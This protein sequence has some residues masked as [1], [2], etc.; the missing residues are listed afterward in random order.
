MKSGPHATALDHARFGLLFLHGCQWNGRRIVSREWVRDATWI[1]TATDFPNWSGGPA[2]RPPSTPRRTAVS[3]RP[4]WSCA[5]PRSCSAAKRCYCLA[6]AV[7]APKTGFCQAAIP[8]H[9]KAPPP[10]PT[11]EVLEETG[12]EVQVGRVAF[13]LETTDPAGDRRLIE[14]VFLA[15]ERSPYA[16]PKAREPGLWPQFVPV[17][18]TPMLELRPPL[19][20]YLRGLHHTRLQETAPYLGN[21]WRAPADD[22]LGRSRDDRDG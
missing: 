5:A 2:T 9:G 12:L 11:R 10:A 13:V 6:V 15:T 20:G 18:D 4:W 22:T 19:A 7:T 14:I 3:D 8:D 16:E 1:H 17:D 21:L